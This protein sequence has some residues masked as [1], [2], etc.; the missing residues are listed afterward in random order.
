MLNYFFV[1]ENLSK[2]IDRWNDK[3]NGFA[4]NFDS[5]IWGTVI[6]LGLLLIAVFF[7]NGMQKK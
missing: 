4:S 3:L 7:I 2:T 1:L 6:F 5:P